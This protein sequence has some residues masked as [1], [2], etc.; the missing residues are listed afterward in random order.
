M[1]G[2]VI[3]SSNPFLSV[4]LLDVNE[5]SP[6]ASLK[7]ILKEAEHAK[8]LGD[9]DK[10]R[11]FMAFYYTR[12]RWQSFAAFCRDICGTNILYDPFHIPMLKNAS[13]YGDAGAHLRHRM[14]LAFR[15][16]LK[17]QIHSVNNPAWDIACDTI[18]SRGDS[19]TS[20][21][22]ASENEQL[23]KMHIRGIQAMLKS[24]RFAQFFG[25]GHGQSDNW[26]ANSFTSGYRSSES[27]ARQKNPTM[28]I[29]SLAGDRTGFHCRKMIA[30]DLQAFKSSSSVEMLEKSWELYGLLFSILDPDGDFVVTGTR[31]SYSDIYQRILDQTKKNEATPGAIQFSTLIQ[32]IV[33]EEGHPT[34]PTRFS[35]EKVVELKSTSTP[36]KWSSQYLL[37]PITDE[38][39]KFSLTDLRY[40]DGDDIQKIMHARPMF[41][42]IGV[43]PN[44]ISAENLR[45][46]NAESKAYSVVVRMVVDASGSMYMTHLYR[47]RPSKLELCEQIWAQ[48]SADDGHRTISVGVQNVDFK[49]LKELFDMHA[50][51]TG[52]YPVFEW[53]ATEQSQRKTDRIEGALEGRV[54]AN[55]LFIQRAEWL[56]S[57]FYQFPFSRT[58][59]GL[60]AITTATKVA[61]VP[62]DV[63]HKVRRERDDETDRHIDRI[64][65]GTGSRRR[66]FKTAY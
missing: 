51:R 19:T 18:N 34:Y 64:E 38:D 11:A 32:P 56:V 44:W 12:P 2:K 26:T 15:G 36:F 53:V 29:L 24:E 50:L 21:C 30:D 39:R 17:S 52:V 59:D 27:A 14:T 31:W 41:A 48:W 33:D 7:T 28:F 4:P 43:D 62:L 65:H 13:G 20:I 8:E 42:V 49:H 54:R 60:D 6:R 1:S 22:L 61:K 40:V 5:I 55:K 57:E 63:E 58:F 45:S 16:S 23:A 66:T 9:D 47:G 10:W 46:G 3:S 37:N 35:A 25:S